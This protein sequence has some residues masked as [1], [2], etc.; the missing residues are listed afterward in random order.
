[1][2]TV[3]IEAVRMQIITL[4]PVYMN[5]FMMGCADGWLPN[6]MY[7]FPTSADNAH[8]TSSSSSSALIPVFSDLGK[9]VFAIPAGILVD[10]YGRKKITLCVTFSTFFTWLGLSLNTSLIAIYIGR[11]ILGLAETMTSATSLIWI[12]EVASPEVRGTLTSLGLIFINTGLI[13]PSIMSVI[14]GSYKSLTWSITFFSFM[15]LA[16]IIWLVETPNYLVSVSK[17][18]QA[19]AILQQI[20]KG[21]KENEITEEFEK[22]KRYIEDEK[23]RRNQLTWL[24]FLKSKAIMKPLLTGI[25]LNVFTVLTG[26]VLIRVYI[27]AILPSNELVSK[28]YYPLIIQIC[29]LFIAFNT[30][31]YIDKFPRRTIFL[32]GAAAMSIINTICALASYI[33]AGHQNNSNVFKWIFIFGNMA[34]VLCYAAVIQPIN[35]ALKAELY[36]QA[37]KGF[38][39]SLAII[40]QALSFIMAFQLYNFVKDFF[41]L[42]VMYVIFS[43]NSLVLYAIVYFLSPEGRGTS[44][45]DLQ[46]KFKEEDAPCDGISVER[47]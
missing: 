2:G 40:S 3:P 35:S 36:P 18:K 47:K 17:L 16:S 19:I 1:M 26:S 45:A 27:T 12:G 4:I 23:N 15:S 34:S 6:A 30:T 33:V 37:M 21:H 38:C 41:Q 24:K 25:L 31:F 39:G 20:R 43:L 44:L 9:I 10:K 11:F 28:K 7:F 8:E 32:Y 46:M 13:L 5:V 42:S 22:L 14:F 29:L